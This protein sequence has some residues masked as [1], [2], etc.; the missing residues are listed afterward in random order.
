MRGDRIRGI[1]R[2]LRRAERR[3]VREFRA[4]LENTRNLVHLSVVLFVPLL[5]A[6]VTALSN[7]LAAFSFFLFPPL[8]AGTYT[9]FADPAGEY[10]SPTRFV[11]G[12][13]AGAA[14]TAAMSVLFTGVVTWAFDIEE[15]AAFSSALLVLVAGGPV[16]VGGRLSYVVSIAASS[17]LVAGAF[18]VWR[19]KF[20]SERARYLYQSTRGDDHVLVPMRGDHPEATAMLGARLAA[21]HEAGKVVL[22][23][24]VDESDAAEGAG[25][26]DGSPPTAAD[27]AGESA[28]DRGEEIPAASPEERR[29]AEGVAAELEERAAAIR[30]RTGVPC[31]VVVAGEDGTPASVAVRTARETNCD[32]IAAGYETERGRLSPYVR[33][34]FRGDV[35]VAVHRSREGR[36]TW[37]RVLV[38]VRRAGDVAHEM[39]DFATRLAGRTGRVAVCHCIDREG[40]RRAAESTLANLV[41]TVSAACETRVARAGIADFLAANAGGYH[42]VILG[43][44]GDR[45]AASRFVARPTFDRL[46]DVEADVIVFDRNRP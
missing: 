15:P 38:P 3:E 28:G 31:E 17:A 45:T 21:A 8:A 9:L 18:V 4:W 5:V 1:L 33:E 23:G 39:L 42:L 30:T 2:R 41:E 44:S 22:L 14:S 36:T 26:P 34:L 16:A 12:L 37:K 10:A 19:R 43:S 32:L 7:A 40:D 25:G 27:G 11:A 35:N 29:A 46:E 20:Y 13:T 6:L 24:F